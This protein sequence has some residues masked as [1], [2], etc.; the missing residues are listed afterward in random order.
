MTMNPCLRH[1]MAG[2]GLTLSLAAQN[3]IVV[4]AA[5]G[6]GAS[7]ADIQP[8]IDAANDGDRILVRAGSYSGF[9]IDGKGL[10]IL[11]ES[12]VFIDRMA[13]VEIRNTTA[14]QP[15]ALADLSIG[16][17]FLFF[18]HTIEN[19]DG[20]V[21]IERTRM[22][23]A[24]TPFRFLDCADVRITASRADAGA[25]FRNSRATI[26]DSVVLVGPGLTTPHDA[27]VLET[28][29]VQVSRCNVFGQSLFFRAGVSAAIAVDGS[30]TLFLSGDGSN[31]VA[32]GTGL[33]K[34]AIL[35]AGRVERDPRVPVLGSGGAPALAVGQDILRHIPSLSATGAPVG[36][37]V[38]VDLAGLPGAAFGLVLGMPGTPTPLPGLAGTVDIGVVLIAI[39]GV[40]G[41]GT[42]HLSLP[43]ALGLNP[44]TELTWQAIAS[45]GI[46]GFALSNSATYLRT[47]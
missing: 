17:P 31:S 12:G 7:F 11:G 23:G 33:P 8:A 27:L 32:A 41:N 19:C 10:A 1:V 25:L 29:Q 2:I 21:T 38:E 13:L 37:Q 35:G 45:D 43:P 4:D 42:F 40:M 16:A 39:G 30:S 14:Q 20:R 34:S 3:T 22:G 15:I 47:R 46:G 9:V 6:P 36:G 26:T 5:N 24:A 28:S 44:G 18:T